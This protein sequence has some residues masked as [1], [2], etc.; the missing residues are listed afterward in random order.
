MPK[1]I[2]GD[3][4]EDFAP[5][6]KKP[7]PQP[8]RLAA[9]PPAAKPEPAEE[10]AVPKPLPESATATR[11][12]FL[13]WDRPVLDAATDLLIGPHSGERL[14]DLSHLLVIVP[15]LHAG[16]RL[17]ET[18]A[19]RAADFDGA[20]VPPMVAPPEFLISPRHARP[21]GGLEVAG[22]A[23]IL[24]LW[25]DL[26]RSIELDDFR[27]LFPIDPVERSFN[28]AIQTA[29]DILK[30]RKTLGEAGLSIAGA[31]GVL[32]DQGMEPARWRELAKLERRALLK[33]E[34]VAL[35]D[36]ESARREAAD[37]GQV[38][39]GITRVIVLATPDPTPLVIRALR[40]ISTHTPVDVAIH[41]PETKANHFDHWG[42]P[43]TDLWTA[44][45]IEIPEPLNTVHLS[46]D[47]AS[48]AEL[49]AQLLS[50]HEQPS[51]LVAIGVPDEEV[52]PPLGRELESCG[53]AA[54]DPAGEPLQHHEMF[55]LLRV[56]ADLLTA[57]P[58]PAFAQL[59]RIPDFARAAAEQFAADGGKPFDHLAVLRN[60]DSLH[61]D[62]LPDNLEHTANALPKRRSDDRVPEQAFL[63]TLVNRWLNR[64]ESEPLGRALPDFLTMVYA[65]R[66]FDP[67]TAADRTY[68][69]ISSAILTYLDELESPLTGNLKTPPAAADLLNLLL[70]LL[71]N[72]PYY[73]DREHPGDRPVIDLQGWLELLWEDAPH[74]IV[75]G[76]NE[77]QVPD[78]IIGDAYLP[79]RA[80]A[81]LGIR[82]NE[83][84]L[85][86]DSYLLTALI[87]SRR[88]GGRIDL[89]V[90]K[91][92]AD[93]TPLSPSRLLFR[94]PDEQ[95]PARAKQLFKGELEQTHAQPA[96][97]TRAWRLE[98]PALP[99]DAKLRQ[100]MYV[101]QFSDYLRC[102][103]RFFLKHGLGM[104]EFD[105]EK[106]EMDN[107]D[108][109]NLCHDALEQF[110][111]DES[112]RD[113]TEYPQIRDYLI[114]QLDKH[115]ARRYGSTLTVPIMIQLE[116][117]KQRLDWAARIQ[118]KERAA[119]WGI[120]DVE[121]SLPYDPDTKLPT[122]EIDGMP[123]AFKIDRIERHDVTG[124]FRVLDYKTSD[125]AQSAADSHLHT[126]NYYQNPEEFPDYALTTGADGKLQ[127]WTNLQLPLYMFA[128]REKYPEAADTSIYAGLFKL[129]KASS[130]TKIDVWETLT[131]NTL[132][133]ARECV[134]AVIENIRQENFWPPTPTRQ[135]PKWDP[136]AKLFFE[137]PVAAV[138]APAPEK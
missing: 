119:G 92:A 11:P 61:S 7:P 31:A 76:F 93:S 116:S 15:T 68:T 65:H 75:T 6:Q 33:L 113:S 38:P 17:R 54:F 83:H 2:Q 66:E 24:L 37:L 136:F 86:R 22:G 8:E 51:G 110:G 32:A 12:I 137:D 105:R 58:Y 1:F 56:I 64:L 14:I 125:K 77:G 128:M 104:E 95:L 120:I 3:L 112:I 4:F 87:E 60:F 9:P 109:G 132:R 47:P 5:Q 129:P 46:A 115:V 111:R 124:E 39:P 44:Q 101:T 34:S 42:R 50:N 72:Q 82:D 74:L 81:A 106:L 126:L 138:K 10:T 26:L 19:T 117:A 135:S 69:E 71:A 118:A 23:Q 96:A 130:E 16:R 102:P 27:N 53:L 94:C 103:F 73:P 59:I 78:A 84:R 122:W 107:R 80:R 67:A 127:H 28:W 108:F 62:H 133:S 97:W 121:W 21:A 134:S 100:R 43:I 79:N 131:A 98:P 18:L 40:N 49:A 55:Y 57:R 45:E 114:E 88:S 85:A 29:G 25:A 91:A 52:I 30:M 89:V 20:V 70:Q 36:H 63:L 41:A 99:P 13:G 35:R 90:G 48:Q 123:I